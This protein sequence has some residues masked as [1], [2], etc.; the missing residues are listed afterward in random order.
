MKTIKF[1]AIMAAAAMLASCG[2]SKKTANS[3]TAS[4]P[5]S[6]S[7]GVNVD[8]P[9]IYESM[10]DDN[11]FRELGTGTHINMQSARDA[12]YDAA[13]ALCRKKLAEFVQGVSSSYSRTAAGQSAVDKTQRMMEGEMNGIVEEMLNN[14]QKTCEKM[15]QDDAGNYHSFIAIQ[16][17]KNAMV[18]KMANALSA[19]E[20]LEIEF[21]RDQFRKYAEEKMEKM[22][23]AKKSAGY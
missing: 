2:S 22:Q 7:V 14:V 18:N 17:P 8:L 15:Q 21:N 4:R 9:C 5:S 12:A 10:D 6:V 23:A 11:Y 19:N 1:L 20:E 3:S 13:K 16:I